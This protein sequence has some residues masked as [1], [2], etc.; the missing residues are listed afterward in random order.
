MTEIKQF[1]VFII[2]CINKLK[3]F[4]LISLFKVNVLIADYK[5]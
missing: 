1:K 5:Y 2:R 3:C 4:G